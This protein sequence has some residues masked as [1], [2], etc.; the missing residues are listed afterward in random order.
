M[1][2]H[3]RSD[4]RRTGVRTH[5]D[6]V[7]LSRKNQTMSTTTPDLPE[8]ISNAQTTEEEFLR[9]IFVRDQMAEWSKQPLIMARADGVC[10]WDVHGKRYLDALSGIYVVAVGH[11]NR[12]VIEAI[13]RQLD[14]LHFSPPMHGTNALAVQLA[15]LLSELAPEY[16][17]ENGSAGWTVKFE[18]G[19]AEVTEAAIKLARQYHKLTGNPGKYKII[20]RY[21]SWHGSTLGSLSASGL[22]SRKTVNEPLAPGFLHVFPPTCYRCPFGKTYPECGITCA[23]LIGDVI[24]MEDP[25]TVAAIMVEPIGHTGGIIDPP[26][27]YLPLLRE[28]CDKHNVLLIFDE[29]ITGIGRTGRLFAAETFGVVPDVLCIGKG[30]GGGY[31]PLSA[32][33]CRR[34]LA[35]AFWGP[36][37]AN[38]GFVEGHTN[39]GNPI[40]CAAGLAGLQD[41]LERDLLANP[42][43]QG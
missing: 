36:A 40:S 1:G 24:D 4:A 25:A 23:T 29:I 21:Q 31:A 19:G 14:T 27:E 22:K 20:S 42:R 5:R 37:A 32:M 10:Y 9:H 15:N 17:S 26:D 43:P 13:R 18:C 28:L 30:L 6:L 11:N 35:E 38:P 34:P 16:A 41:I 7:L 2:F 8:L 3:R 12:R 33:I 39:E